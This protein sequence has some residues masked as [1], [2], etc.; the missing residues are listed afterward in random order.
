MQIATAGTRLA[1]AA[2][3]PD[4]QG[5]ASVRPLPTVC[6]PVRIATARS[7]KAAWVG[8]GQACRYRRRICSDH[9]RHDVKCTLR[10]Y[11]LCRGDMRGGSGVGRQ[12]VPFLPRASNCPF[13]R[14]ARG[15]KAAGTRELPGGVPAAEPTIAIG[16]FGARAVSHEEQAQ[17]ESDTLRGLAPSI[18]GCFV[19]ALTLAPPS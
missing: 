4:P 6:A 1:E 13:P 16:V 3:F 2:G 18:R 8:R 19:L 7:R 12:V 5:G 17:R 9:A 11:S 14:D 15:R 10:E